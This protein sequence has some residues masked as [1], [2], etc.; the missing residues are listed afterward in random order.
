MVYT[1]SSTKLEIPVSAQEGGGGKRKVVGGR[2][3]K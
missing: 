1:L 2:G 3:E